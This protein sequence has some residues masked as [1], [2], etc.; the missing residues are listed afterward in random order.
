MRAPQ[1]SLLFAFAIAVGIAALTWQ[2]FRQPA[3]APDTEDSEEPRYYLDNAIWLRYDESGAPLQ[4]LR[5]SRVSLLDDRSATL[6]Q[7]T[8]DQLGGDH[9]A[10]TLYAPQGIVPPGQERVRLEGGVRVNGRWPE[11]APLRMQTASLWVDASSREI[12][13][14]T[15]VA[16]DGVQRT[17]DAGG[18][19]AD[20][21]A[22]RV[23]LEGQV[24]VHY[25][26][27]D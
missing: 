2:S 13:T 27:L 5:S 21:N 9:G 16:V 15:A 6:S 4:R 22:D 19:R 24:K 8:V 14:D 18:L 26:A 17:L 12:Y 20:W 11:D 10:W 25:D 7:V 1:G 3:I 23:Q